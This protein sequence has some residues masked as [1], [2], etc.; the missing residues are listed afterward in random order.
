MNRCIQTIAPLAEHFG[1]KIRLEWGIGEG[2]TPHLFSAQPTPLG[3][4]I[5]YTALA[6]LMQL[7]SQNRSTGRR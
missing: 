3:L 4:P 6:M 2:L 5:R 7:K 1:V